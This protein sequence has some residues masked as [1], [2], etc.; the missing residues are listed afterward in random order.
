[1]RTLDDLGNAHSV[2][3]RRWSPEQS[4]EQERILVLARSALDFISATGQRYDFEDFFKKP[5]S[6]GPPLQGGTAELRERMDRTRR[7]FEKVRD[8]PESAEEVAQSQAILDTLRYI[9]S[10]GQQDAFADYLEHVEANAPPFVVAAFDTREE[11]EAWLASHPHLP[12][13]ANVLVANEYRDVFYARETNVRY[14]SRNHVL[15]RY[16]KQLEEKEEPVAVAFFETPAE[17]EAWWRAQVEPSRRAWVQVGGELYLAAYFPNIQHRTLFPRSP[18]CVPFREGGKTRTFADLANAHPAIGRRWSP[19]QS[20]EQERILG[21]ARDALDFIYAAG[22]RYDFEDFLKKPDSGGP[23]PRGG[24]AE[25]KE[26]MDRTRRFFEKVREEPEFAEEVAQSQAILDTLR[27]IESTGRQDAFAD[28]LEHVE[29]NAPYF[30][31]ASFDTREDAEAWLASNP[32]LPDPARVLVANEYHVVIY[33]RET[34]FR[35]LRRID[36]LQ[37]YFEELEEKEERPVAV[38][39]FETRAEAESWWRAQAEPARRA[40]V[41]VGGELH[42]AAYFPNI[43]H[44]ALFPRAKRS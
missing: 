17:A 4:P 39:S 37:G 29:A 43:H 15:Q 12:D 24:T 2:I 32:H 10:T 28:Y 44:R 7:F 25:L 31:V 19:D 21:L 36:D 3:G 11:A 9:E 5:D 14:L 22:Q 42:L 18:L 1:M 34:N 40:W 35:R 27:Y 30:V 20:P 16:F 38:A 6:G 8:A 23:P 33:D 41:R 13:P 26:R